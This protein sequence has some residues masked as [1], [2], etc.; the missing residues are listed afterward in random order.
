M[1]GLLSQ[2]ASPQALV[3]LA[4]HAFECLTQASN[5]IH[6]ASPWSTL[7]GTIPCSG[8]GIQQAFPLPFCSSFPYASSTWCCRPE[9]GG[10]PPWPSA[11]GQDSEVKMEEC[12]DGEERGSHRAVD[13]DQKSCCPKASSQWLPVC[14]SQDHVSEKKQPITSLECVL[15]IYK[16]MAISDAC[17]VWIP[18]A[19]VPQGFPWESGTEGTSWLWVFH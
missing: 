17:V 6:T 16:P 8:V 3:G 5:W 7:L 19:H 4:E 14:L 18:R 2:P 11:G 1:L 10:T 15:S 12:S 9:R 13:Q